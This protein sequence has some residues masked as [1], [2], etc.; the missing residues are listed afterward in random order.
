MKDLW[1][2]P[3]MEE[4]TMVFIFALLSVFAFG[5]NQLS[6]ASLGAVPACAEMIEDSQAADLSIVCTLGTVKLETD[7][8]PAYCDLEL[9]RPSGHL[10]MKGASVEIVDGVFQNANGVRVAK[11]L[12]ENAD[13]ERY[14]LYFRASEIELG[15]HEAR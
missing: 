8:T 14:Y 7:V 13:G 2:P 5:I 15:D 6:A 10:Y 3:S 11:A 12:E 4:W 9:S 1:D